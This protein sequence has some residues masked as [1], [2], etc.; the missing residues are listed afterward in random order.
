MKGSILLRKLKRAIHFD[1]HTVKGIDCILRDFDTADFAQTLSDSGVDYITFFA[2]CNN[3]LCYYPTKTGVMYPGLKIDLLGEV[4]K[5]C[6]TRDIGVSAYINVGL[7]HEQAL[8][9][10]D[11][12]RVDEQG[13][14]LNFGGNLVHD[15]GK[16][17]DNAFTR[18]MCFNNPRYVEYVF[19]N[20]MEQEP[21]NLSGLL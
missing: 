8:L 18:T 20:G 13:R 12:S 16:T 6:H 15:C 9:H 14:V 10:Q 4:V 3:G 2:A 19:F 5:E 1:F 21:K 7:N 17:G 11:W